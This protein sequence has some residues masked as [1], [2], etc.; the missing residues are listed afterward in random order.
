[1]GPVGHI[2]AEN[3]KFLPRFQD[4]C[5][6]HGLKPTYLTTYEMA[7]DPD[8]VRFARAAEAR[9][10]AEVGMHLRAWDSPPILSGR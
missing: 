9:K 8:F 10:T 1:M 6:K 5:E 2:H 4:L 3:A 7:C